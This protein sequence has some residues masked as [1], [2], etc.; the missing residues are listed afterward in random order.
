MK[1][2]AEIVSRK[3]DELSSC[4]RGYPHVCHKNPIDCEKIVFVEDLK[5]SIGVE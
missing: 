4:Q 3:I 2:K 5:K 1:L